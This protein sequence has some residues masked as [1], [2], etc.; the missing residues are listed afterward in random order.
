MIWCGRTFFVLADDRDAFSRSDDLE[1]SAIVYALR[2]LLAEAFKHGLATSSFPGR[3]QEIEA[4]RGMKVLVSH[5][6]K[7][8]CPC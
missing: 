8:L 6:E 4:E 3:W 7:P 1:E 5:E 2:V